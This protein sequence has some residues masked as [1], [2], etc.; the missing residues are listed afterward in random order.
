MP[1]VKH[2]KNELKMQKDALRRFSRYLPTLKLKKQQLQLEIIRVQRLIDELSGLIKDLE[3][4]VFAW[5]DVFAED[6]DV[7]K[8]LSLKDIKTE[9]VNI[10]GIDMPHFA[11]AEFIEQTYDFLLTP[12]WVDAGIK[13][14]KEF[15]ELRAKQQVLRKQH[16]ILREELRITVQRVNLFEKVKIPQAQENIRVINIY[17]GDLR[18]AEVVRGKIAKAKIEN[19]REALAV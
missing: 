1:K 11:G 17:L 19:K 4:R 3:R 7:G 14:C 8:L 13:A 9:I 5:V 12:L 6:V 2:T 10:A 16:E 15:I 18:T